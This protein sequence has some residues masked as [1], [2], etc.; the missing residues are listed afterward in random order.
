MNTLL[1]IIPPQ[2]LVME[3]FRSALVA[4]GAY[5]HRKLPTMDIRLV[6]L[7]AVHLSKVAGSLSDELRS[8]RGRVLAGISTLTADYQAALKVAGELKKLDKGIIT[9][10][11]GH[12]AS[13]DAAVILQ[14]HSDVDFVISNEGEL[15][16]FNLAN[17]YP[18]VENIPG[19][20]FRSNGGIQRNKPPP[21]LSQEDLDLV[22]LTFE[23]W[24]LS[25]APGKFDHVTYVSARG[26]PLH[27]AF[28][29]VA[30]QAIR[31]KS[32]SRVAEDIASLVDRGFSRLAIEDNFFAHSVRRTRDVCDALS[33][34]RAN[35]MKFSWDCQTR[36]ESMD[37]AGILPLMQDAGCDAVYLGVES[38]DEETLSFLGKTPNPSKY[39]DRLQERVIPELLKSNIDCFINLQFG[40][41]GETDSQMNKVIDRMRRLGQLA[42]SRGREI[43]IF[44]QLFVVYPGTFHFIEFVRAKL[45]SNKIFESFTKWEAE[46]EPI[47]EWLG[48][49]FAHGTGGLPLGILD[50]RRLRDGQF[51]V[52]GASTARIEHAIS[53]L[54]LPGVRVFRYGEY[55]VHGDT[56]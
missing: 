56:Q 45:F 5:I 18:A 1:L 24:E 32:V 39:L 44:P 52:D 17:C 8:V 2:R 49:T 46:Q 4:L 27:C 55:L 29:A 10:M 6:D 28:C 13:G 31:G 34:L 19:L 30:N 9:V 36:V 54:N 33:G 15:P 14:E 16:L 11:G 53:R 43:T 20:A 50:D 38:L 25:Q 41:P 47:L 22:P 37:R 48:Q 51:T 35:G 26:C 23:G 12:H 7:S 42:Q 21:L 3:G 40:V